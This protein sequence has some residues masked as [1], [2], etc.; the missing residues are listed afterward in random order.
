MVSLAAPGPLIVN[1]SEINITPLSL[2]SLMAPVRPSLKTI[3]SAPGFSFA[4]AMTSRSEPGPSSSKLVTMK[5]AGAIR[6]SRGSSIVD[7]Y[8]DSDRWREDFT[9]NTGTGDT[10]RFRFVEINVAVAPVYDRRG[11]FAAH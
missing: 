4:L 8:F 6:D 9:D 10:S 3:E 7:R 1:V 11:A 5:V 2:V